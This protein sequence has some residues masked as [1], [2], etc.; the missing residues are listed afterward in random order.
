MKYSVKF[1]AALLF[2]TFVLGIP[3]AYSQQDEEIKSEKIEELKI[4]FI[5]K[6]LNLSSE[7]AQKFWPIYNEMS[8]KL[9]EEKKIQ[10]KV[11]KEIKEQQSI[12]SEADF[13]KKSGAIMDAQIAEAIIK[14]E[15]HDKIGGLIGYKKATKLLSLEQRFK[16]ELLNRLNETHGKQ[17]PKGGKP[18]GPRPI[19]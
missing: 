13:K 16:R 8:D 17:G 4:A 2:F 9:K 6:E 10:R 14:K 3:V 19:K 1:S 11:G 12:F 18:G 15:Y 5:T 7:E